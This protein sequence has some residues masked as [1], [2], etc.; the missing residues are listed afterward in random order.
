MKLKMAMLLASA[1][2]ST[3]APG[4][5]STVRAPQPRVHAELFGRTLSFSLPSQM[6]LATNK[7]DDTHLLME[8]IPNGE[9][10][11]NWT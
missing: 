6:Q 4:R 2:V 1:L 3:A 9:S 11:A 7:R 5:S 10:L 8:F